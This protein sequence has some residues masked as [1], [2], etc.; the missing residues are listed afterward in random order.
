ML[1]SFFRVKPLN[2]TPHTWHWIGTA[3]KMCI[4]TYIICINILIRPLSLRI[5]HDKLSTL[6][7]F[8][9][10]NLHITWKKKN[11]GNE[12]TRNKRARK[13]QICYGKN[14]NVRFVH[15]IH[16]YY[17]MPRFVCYS[18]TFHS[19]YIAYCSPSP[20]IH[21]LIKDTKKYRHCVYLL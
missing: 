20:H 6:I 17:K 2:F 13:M 21:L 14:R 4:G 19:A 16:A 11:I 15:W 10:R 3:L 9:N 1:F 12:P 18:V 7:R 5:F 8:I